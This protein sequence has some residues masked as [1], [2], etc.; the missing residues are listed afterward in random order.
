MQAAV[1]QDVEAMHAA[2]VHDAETMCAAAICNAE[3]MC[4]AA[5]RE[6]ETINVDCTHILQ[7]PHGESMQ[8]I[9]REAIEEEGWEHLSFLN[10]CGAA[11]QPCPPEACGVL[12]YPL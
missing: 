2:T 6:A 11:L 5:I 12:M 3:G 9:E 4:A 1:I 10:A 8:D 7:Q